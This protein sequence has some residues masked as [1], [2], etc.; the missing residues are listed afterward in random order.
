MVRQGLHWIEAHTPQIKA[1]FLLL[2]AISALVCGGTTL[3]LWFLG[4]S[5][6]LGVID[7]FVSVMFFWFFRSVFLYLG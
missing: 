4:R 3:V 5:A 7:T 1:G 6:F 2:W